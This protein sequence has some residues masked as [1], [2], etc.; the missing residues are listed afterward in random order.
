MNSL[1]N[2]SY[3]RGVSRV[4]MSIEYRVFGMTMTLFLSLAFEGMSHTYSSHFF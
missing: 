4:K 2:G 3:Q 1:A